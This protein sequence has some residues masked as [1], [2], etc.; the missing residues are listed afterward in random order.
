[1]VVTSYILACSPCNCIGIVY[2]GLVLAT[3]CFP[4]AV[5]SLLFLLFWKSSRA[6]N[7]QGTI[8]PSNLIIDEAPYAA[9]LDELQANLS[10]VSLGNSPPEI[11]E[12]V[13][14]SFISPDCYPAI[15]V[16][17][18]CS[19]KNAS[20]ISSVQLWEKTDGRST[21]ERSFQFSY[22]VLS[23]NPDNYTVEFQRTVQLREIGEFTILA[24]EY[25][26]QTDMGAV[27]ANATVEVLCEL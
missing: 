1:M 16:N 3:W 22:N 19:F 4:P 5:Y 23:S 9:T 2:S 7:I 11:G 20:S 13:P 25:M 27:T 17:F 14:I 24:G 8:S 10:S 21:F 18:T 12:R 26:C 15:T 6:Q